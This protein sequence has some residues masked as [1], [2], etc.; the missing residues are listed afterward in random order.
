MT[1]AAW[2]D[3]VVV[4]GLC[5][6]LWWLLKFL[7]RLSEKWRKEMEERIDVALKQRK[8]VVDPF[9]NTNGYGWDYCM[10]F[11]V[12]PIEMALSEEQ[13][14][15]SLKS[16]LNKMADAGLQTKLF[17]SVQH[18]EVIKRIHHISSILIL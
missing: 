17:Y 9:R 4:V 6:I 10:V 2:I 11:K 5:L 7:R 8:R 13:K 12:L 15:F 18:D 3:F 14:K 16:L 1:A